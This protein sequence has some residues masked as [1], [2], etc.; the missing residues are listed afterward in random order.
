MNNIC[1]G[2]LKILNILDFRDHFPKKSIFWNFR[3]QKPKILTNRDS[4]LVELLILRLLVFFICVLLKTASS[5]DPRSLANF[6][7]KV[8][9]S[10]V[11]KSTI[12][13]KFSDGCQKKIHGRCQIV[14]WEGLPSFT[15]I[16]LFVFELSRIFGRG[17]RQTPPRSSAGYLWPKV[18]SVSWPP[19]YK[20]MGEK[21]KFPK[22]ILIRYVQDVQNHAQLGHCWWP[23]CNFA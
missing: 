4:H 21:L 6:R 20:S 13:R 17:R 10:D 19:H 1:S 23:W 3:G 2:F 18:R 16:A 5:T 15:S 11:T 22:Y 8:A 14:V 9:C 12:S 7:P